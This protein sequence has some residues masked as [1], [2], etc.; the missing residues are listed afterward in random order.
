VGNRVDA[1]DVLDPDAKTARAFKGRVVGHYRPC[2]PNPWDDFKFVLEDEGIIE[3]LPGLKIQ[4]ERRGARFRMRR[5]GKVIRVEWEP[6][7][8]D[9][10][11]LSVDD[12]RERR[13]LFLA[14]F[15]ESFD[16]AQG[17]AVA[18]IARKLDS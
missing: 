16:E 12:I 4:L 8:K 9:L 10:Q 7:D 14:E 5:Q 1:R 15:I 18:V 17:H 6:S 11:M 2:G 3:V 13:R